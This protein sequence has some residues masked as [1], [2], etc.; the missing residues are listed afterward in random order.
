[1]IAKVLE[2]RERESTVGQFLLDVSVALV[3]LIY[4]LLAVALPHKI[5]K[6]M[7]ADRVRRFVAIKA[8]GRWVESPKYIR[9]LRVT[10][11]VAILASMLLFYSALA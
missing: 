5:R 2:T 6:W 8:Y 4:G 9:H 7:V 3:V 1:M 11:G 10:G